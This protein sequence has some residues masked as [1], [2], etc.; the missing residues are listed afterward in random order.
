[1]AMLTLL[2]KGGH[3][4]VLRLGEMV[5]AMFGWNS[6]FRDGVLVLGYPTYGP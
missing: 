1:M 4:F 5:A 2:T 3:A 6:A